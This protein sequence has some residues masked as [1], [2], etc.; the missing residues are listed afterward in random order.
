MAQIADI[1][2]ER[3]CNGTPAYIKKYGA[4]PSAFCS[5][6]SMDFPVAG[7]SNE[8]T[9]KALSEARRGKE[10]IFADAEN[11]ITNLYR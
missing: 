5:E 11:M 1:I 8:T 7:I 9:E 6:N 2:V 10:K 3:N 4:M